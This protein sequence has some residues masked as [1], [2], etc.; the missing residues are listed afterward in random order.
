MNVWKKFNKRKKLAEYNLKVK[1]LSKQ[2]HS[3]WAKQNL[4]YNNNITGSIFKQVLS[5]NLNITCVYAK[6][7]VFTFYAYVFMFTFSWNTYMLNAL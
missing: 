1:I 2:Q 4:R 3:D 6:Y 5:F 7:I